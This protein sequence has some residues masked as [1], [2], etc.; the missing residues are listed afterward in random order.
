MQKKNSFKN[1]QNKIKDLLFQ[2]VSLPRLRKPLLTGRKQNK[3]NNNQ[4]GSKSKSCCLSGFRALAVVLLI[5]FVSLIAGFLAG[6]FSFVYFYLLENQEMITVEQDSDEGTA[7]YQ[8]QT[9]TEDMI[10]RAVEESSPS[11]V[12]IIITKDMPVFEEYYS[13]PFGDLF[14]IP[15][16]RQKGTEEQEIG[17]G[18]GFI[19]S[20]S[21]MTLTNKHVVA[22]E[23][24]EYTILTNEGKRYPA[25]VLARDP[26]Q[27]LAFLEIDKEKLESENKEFSLED[28]KPIRLGDSEELKMG[29]TVVA[30]GN[31]LGEF[32]NTISVG[33]ISGLGRTITASG[34]GLVE[35]LED[36]I[37]TDAAINRGNSGGPLLNL[38]GEVVG[39][40]VAMAETAQNIGFS[41]PI[42]RAKRDIEQLE[43][44]GEIIYPFLGVRYVMI[45]PEI[46]E[47]QDLS[48]GHGA[49]LM[50][51][52]DGQSA[53]VPDS[54]ADKSGLKEGDI[55]LELNG[56]VVGLENSL[57]NLVQEYS[58][59]DEIELKVLSEGEEKIVSLVLIR[60]P[61]E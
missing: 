34:E 46:K 56:K 44:I 58:P 53:I 33:V 2:R 18:T 23:A 6:T 55:I 11:V 50:P 5:I 14:S 54:P 52:D 26:V 19:I 37:Q 30:I 20:Q 22:D 32:R 40:N 47:K 28:F 45:T 8:A 39:V 1:K 38:K 36:V 49:L 31:A 3:K 51:A 25:R 10:I 35:T 60:W 16:Y 59:G 43:T 21:G 27:D 48:V 42:N 4:K 7:G 12:S 24:A 57:V 29:Q 9:V 15:Q 13:N 17:G 41:I 61:T